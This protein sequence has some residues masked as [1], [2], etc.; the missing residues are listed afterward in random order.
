MFKS[1]IMVWLSKREE[2]MVLN[3]CRE[4]LEKVSET[5]KFTKQVFD[6]FCDEKFNELEESYQKAFN[7]EREADDV[8]H[9]ILMQV[10][11]GPLHPID[12]EEVIRLVLTADD[13]AENAKSGARKL[14]FS[15]TDCLTEE[16]KKNV[17]EMAEKCV[18]MVDKLISAFECLGKNIKDAIKMA[19]EVEIIEEVIDEDPSLKRYRLTYFGR[20]EVEAA[21][22]DDSFMRKRQKTLRKIYWR[23]HRNIPDDL[24]T[25]FSGFLDSFEKSHN[26]ALDSQEKKIE[27]IQIIDE[28]ASKMEKLGEVY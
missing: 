4:H 15:K 6:N 2:R 3:L 14:R 26:Y 9:K 18:E 27:L 8:K 1:N 16:L 7:K 13:V 17:K 22:A 21:M 20:E 23:L 10:S 19:N 24:Y 28:A 5:V 12:R 11:T 25:S